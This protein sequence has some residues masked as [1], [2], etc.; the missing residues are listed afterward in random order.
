MKEILMKKPVFAALLMTVFLGFWAFQIKD[1]SPI[2]D[3]LTDQ[4]NWI[5]QGQRYVD[6]KIAEQFSPTDPV[7]YLTDTNEHGWAQ[8]LCNFE[9][10]ASTFG[11]VFGLCTTPYFYLERSRDPVMGDEVDIVHDEK[12]FIVDGKVLD[13]W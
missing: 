3:M 10:Y 2:E 1:R 11:T 8:T 9:Q 13:D 6:T 7:L 5:V 4:T 12:P